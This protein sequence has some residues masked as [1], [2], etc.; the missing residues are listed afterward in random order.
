MMSLI[1]NHTK[2]DSLKVFSDD[3]TV[4]ILAREIGQMMNYLKVTGF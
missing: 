4:Q 3:Q 1:T 2:S